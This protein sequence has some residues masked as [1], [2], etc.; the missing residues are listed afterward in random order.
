MSKLNIF[1][2]FGILFLT[3]VLLGSGMYSNQVFS[4]NQTENEAEIEADIE[5][6]N[7]CK[8]DTE[9]ENE[10]EINNSLNIINNGTQSQQ[11]QTDTQTCEGCFTDN[12]NAEQISAFELA[13]ADATSGEI[14]SIAEFCDFVEFI[15]NEGGNEGLANIIGLLYFA[16]NNAGISQSDLD[17][18][19]ECI[20]EVYGIVLPPPL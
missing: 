16:G 15:I 18:I 8:N 4:Q 20:E 6:E 1:S 3:S 19:A 7:K 5:Q 11:S 10:N 17:A 12:L 13:L 14:S 9:C 2:I